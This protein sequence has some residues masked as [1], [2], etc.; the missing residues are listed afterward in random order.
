[1]INITA[2]LTNSVVLRLDKIAPI[3]LFE[4]VS[5]QS[6]ETFFFT[7]ENISPSGRFFECKVYEVS[8]TN[9]LIALTA[10]IP[11]IKLSYGGS[12]NYTLYGTDKYDLEPTDDILDVGKLLY[13]NN[14]W[15]DYFGDSEI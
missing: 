11:Q 9:D 2:G 6:N 7:A 5:I 12:Y 4:V 15:F 1:M 3:Y 14:E 8:G 10:S 13:K